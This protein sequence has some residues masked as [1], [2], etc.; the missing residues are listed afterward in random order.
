ME[1]C[2]SDILQE[3]EALDQGQQQKF[4][5]K[6]EPDDDFASPREHSGDEGDFPPPKPETSDQDQKLDPINVIVDESISEIHATGPGES[7]LLIDPGAT[8]SLLTI[9]MAE[10]LLR[11][12]RIFN[13]SPS[14]KNFKTASGSILTAS[15]KVDLVLPF[16]RAEAFVIETGLTAPLLG[17]PHLRQ[18]VLHIDAAKLTTSVGSTVQEIGLVRSSNGHLFYVT[19]S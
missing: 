18:C 4:K 13:I 16:S 5:G 19:E 14:E 12:G 8:S 6:E 3:K 15:T 9:A 10:D 1:R 2:L 17:M 7:A 11:Q